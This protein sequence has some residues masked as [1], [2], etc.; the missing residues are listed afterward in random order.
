MINLFFTHYIKLPNVFI[1]LLEHQNY[2]HGLK[3]RHITMID[4][5][6]FELREGDG[7]RGIKP[8]ISL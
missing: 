7:R 3:F 1:I 6:R 4:T 5:F 8:E 2:T